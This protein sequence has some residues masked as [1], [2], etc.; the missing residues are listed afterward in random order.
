MFNKILIVYLCNNFQKK[1]FK[2]LIYQKIICSIINIKSSITIRI[3]FLVMNIFLCYKTINCSATNIF[4]QFS[5]IIQDEQLNDM[6]INSDGIQF[7]NNSELFNFPFTENQTHNSKN[8]DFLSNKQIDLNEIE[9]QNNDF[10]QN[11][12][13]NSKNCELPDDLTSIRTEDLITINKNDL[14]Q[15]ISSDYNT[16]IIQKLNNSE[17]YIEIDHYNEEVI[18][19]FKC[20]SKNSNVL[21]RIT[22]YK[23]DQNNDLIDQNIS[24]TDR[25]EIFQENRILTAQSSEFDEI[26]RSFSS[27]THG[28]NSF[29]SKI[30]QI[31]QNELLVESEQ[32]I[33]SNITQNEDKILKHNDQSVYVCYDTGNQSNSDQFES[34]K[35]DHDGYLYSCSQQ[36]DYSGRT[37]K[38]CHL[39]NVFSTP[40]NT[41]NHLDFQPNITIDTN[42]DSS[43]QSNAQSPIFHIDS[44]METQ[45]SSNDI[46]EV[47]DV[48]QFFNNHTQ[49]LNLIQPS[50][51]LDSMI[52]MNYYKHNEDLSTKWTQSRIYRI[53][54]NQFKNIKETFCELDNRHNR[55]QKK[56]VE[57]ELNS[58]N[59]F[60]KHEMLKILLFEIENT[61]KIIISTESSRIKLSISKCFKTRLRNFCLFDDCDICSD[62]KRFKLQTLMVSEADFE[63]LKKY[64]FLADI[65][66]FFRNDTFKF[67]NLLSKSINHLYNYFLSKKEKFFTLLE[68]DII[69]N[70]LPHKKIDKNRIFKNIFHNFKFLNSELKCLLVPEFFPLIIRML[71]GGLSY[72]TRTHVIIF[73]QL[74]FYLH[75]F[76]NFFQA[77]SLDHF[78][79]ENSTSQKKI[80]EN[81]KNMISFFARI[82]FVE[83]LVILITRE[84]R[85]CYFYDLYILTLYSAN[86]KYVQ[87]EF[88]GIEKRN[89]CIL[90][91]Y[92]WW[93]CILL[94]KMNSKSNIINIDINGLLDIMSF[95]FQDIKENINILKLIQKHYHLGCANQIVS[96]KIEQSEKIFL[97]WIS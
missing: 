23:S 94:T 86:C 53:N 15:L 59:F 84:K 32:N 72:H 14:Y 85:I 83:P 20:Y 67:R 21:S 71:Y 78:L 63:N 89:M 95:N 39:K 81:K 22:S 66:F 87:K 36:F 9:H 40:K 80:N 88:L 73:F 64:P 42:N 58:D 46:I 75:S 91:L 1:L 49:D 35:I 6:I 2:Y 55:L 17:D 82:M 48:Q 90:K 3:L 8:N 19:N 68:S 34:G 5:P 96:R 51:Y 60:S 16:D 52:Q 79:D 27:Y 69:L 56:I 10:E 77:L 47:D 11:F 31:F 37:D 74:I 50:Q 7:P 54:Y 25:N 44:F 41:V 70:Q 13:Y 93:V 4:E 30:P 29:N 97:E 24:A 18:E 57:F 38:L 43:L 33:V 92:M 76:N 45:N 65:N 62:P 61:Q 12:E 28:L 26:N